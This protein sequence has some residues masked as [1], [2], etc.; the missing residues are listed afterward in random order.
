MR[1]GGGGKKGFDKERFPGVLESQQM[2]YLGYVQVNIYICI[3]IF[4]ILCIIV[5]ICIYKYICD[6]NK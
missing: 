3:N 4:N 5:Y 1:G 6:S 2:T